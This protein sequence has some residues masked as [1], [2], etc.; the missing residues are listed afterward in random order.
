MFY[1]CFISSPK[2]SY[3][4]QDLLKHLSDTIELIMTNNT[5]P[6]VILAGDFNQLSHSDICAMGIQGY[7]AKRLGG[8]TVEHGGYV[9]KCGVESMK[10]QAK[11]VKWRIPAQ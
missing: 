3:S 1:L 4:D 11:V 10:S 9:V 7:N 8:L 5:S 2:A 6:I